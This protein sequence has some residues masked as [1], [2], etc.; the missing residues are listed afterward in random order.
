MFL[1]RLFSPF[2]K[3][4][5][6]Q[7]KSLVLL[8]PRQV[9]KSS[10]L[11]HDFP[12]V[13]SFVFDG[14]QDLY[15]AKANPDLFLKSFK[16]P[17][18]LDEVQYVPELL[19]ALKRFMDQKKDMGQYFL[20]GSQNFSIMNKIVES[21]AG[22]AS[23]LRLY[24]MTFMELNSIKEEFWLNAYL[25]RDEQKLLNT[26]PINIPD[27]IFT[28]IWKGG[29]PGLIGKDNDY[30]E[31]FFSS[32]FE[33]YIQKDI[34]TLSQ[35][36]NLNDFSKF[37]RLLSM[38]AGNEINFSELGREIGIANSTAI[39]WKDLLLH[40]FVWNE[41]M[42]FS[43]NTLKRLSKKP[44]GYLMDTGFLCYLNMIQSPKSLASHPHNGA[45]FENYILNQIQGYM[46]AKFN[47]PQIYHWRTSNQQEVDFILE[48]DG[49]LYPI[50]IK[51][52]S[53]VCSKDAKGIHAFMDTY[54]SSKIYD[55][56]IIYTGDKVRYVTDKV[57]AVPWNSFLLSM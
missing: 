53:T 27:N 20:T 4:M 28:L 31:T 45:I 52:K 37:V 8:G 10:I 56:I 17:L 26:K 13:E 22:R 14:I 54:P 41:I 39:I 42:P 3:K 1:N 30:F 23:I 15:D 50:E 2:L 47:K 35:I 12:N 38:K 44:K 9:G 34:R 33:T 6:T 18:I 19:S 29:M 40:S 7:S 49:H 21:M 55:G 11:E 32:Y 51:M 43:G 57:I 48:Y 25:E 24:P 5:A 46:S 36:N 16:P